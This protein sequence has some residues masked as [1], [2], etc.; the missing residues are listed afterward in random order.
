[1]PLPKISTPSYEL[2]IPSTKK[3]IKFRPF[4]V[5]EEKILILAMES[6]DNKQIASAVKDV[7]AACILTRGIKVETLSTFD[8]EYL[9][10]NIRGKSV[11]E[12]VEVT[13]TCPDDNETK[14]PSVINLD[15]IKVQIDDDHSPDIKLDDEY[16][17]R[18]KYPSMDEFIKTNFAV[19]GDI[20]VDDTFKLIASCVDQVYSEEESWA[21]SDCTKKELSQFIESLN[22]KQF[23]EIEKFFDTMPKLSHTVKVTNPNTKVESEVILEGLQSFFG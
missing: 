12:E 22:S 21:A 13:I 16:V 7:I 11:G 14:V 23:K 17:L 5:K 4:L 6:Q 10:L 8:I 20:N 18:M 1:M 15:E 9:F 3:K 19:E 2:V